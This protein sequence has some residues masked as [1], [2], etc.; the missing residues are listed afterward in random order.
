MLTKLSAN[1]TLSVFSKFDGLLNLRS[2]WQEIANLWLAV[3]WA[4][5][6]NLSH[7]KEKQIELCPLYFFLGK[8]LEPYTQAE[9]QF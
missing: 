1:Q 8:N 2:A 6:V 7:T 3:G 5:I 9:V 4:E